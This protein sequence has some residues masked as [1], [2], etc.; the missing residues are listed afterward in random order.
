MLE[1]ALRLGVSHISVWK[2]LI[3]RCIRYCYYIVDVGSPGSPS[4]LYYMIFSA[5]RVVWLSLVV[6]ERFTW[7]CK[8]CQP[9]CEQAVG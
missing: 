5:G 9:A 6:L 7:L 2:I 8:E 3:F 1:R 4:L